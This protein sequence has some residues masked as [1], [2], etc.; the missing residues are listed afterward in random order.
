MPRRTR[1]DRRGYVPPLAHEGDGK[2]RAFAYEHY[3]ER[4]T[5]SFAITPKGTA[6]LRFDPSAE[7]RLIQILN[8]FLLVR[9]L[10]WRFLVVCCLV[11]RLKAWNFGQKRKATHLQGA[12]ADAL[13]T[14][15]LD[16]QVQVGEHEA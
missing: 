10:P 5:W 11:I 2:E 7:G 15:V 1:G 13:Y 14:D 16:P 3:I 8:L 12:S 4:I 9:R 6:R